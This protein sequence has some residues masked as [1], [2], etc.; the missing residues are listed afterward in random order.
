M[1]LNRIQIVAWQAILACAAGGVLAGQ[2]EREPRPLGSDVDI[3]HLL[4]VAESDYHQA[5]ARYA[6]FR[7]LVSSGQPALSGVKSISV[8]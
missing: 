4:A 7:E 6:T 5:H 8:N 3:V 2:T 1:R